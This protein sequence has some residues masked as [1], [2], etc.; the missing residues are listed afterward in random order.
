MEGNYLTEDSKEP[1]TKHTTLPDN[2]QGEKKTLTFTS[3]NSTND[4]INRV[5]MKP[6]RGITTIIPKNVNVPQVTLKMLVESNLLPLNTD[7]YF[8]IDKVKYNGIIAKDSNGEP[9]LC[10]GQLYD[11]NPHT[12]IAAVNLAIFFL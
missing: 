6:L 7:I 5:D 11:K 8:V 12:F 4:M 10:A 9:A 3:G 2:I 1:F